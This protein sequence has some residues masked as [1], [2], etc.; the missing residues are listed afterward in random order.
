MRSWSMLVIEVQEEAVSSKLLV[1]LV[2]R[3]GKIGKFGFFEM[4]GLNEIFREVER[5]G[6]FFASLLKATVYSKNG[7]E[8]KIKFFSIAIADCCY[9][10]LSGSCGEDLGEVS[11]FR[12]RESTISEKKNN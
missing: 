1:G 2:E 4:F 8:L 9:L 5:L 7:F 6:R 12:L 11:G 10:L 3:L